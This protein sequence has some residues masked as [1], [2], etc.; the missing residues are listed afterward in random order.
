MVFQMYLLTRTYN[1]IVSYFG[2]CENFY[3]SLLFSCHIE[4]LMV[5]LRNCEGIIY[6]V[7]ITASRRIMDEW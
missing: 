2:T 7:A 5:L 1:A 3:R 4:G 6:H